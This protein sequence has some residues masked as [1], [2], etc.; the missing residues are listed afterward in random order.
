M[1]NLGQ[2]VRGVGTRVGDTSSA[3]AV[4]I[5]RYVNFRYK[6]IWERF[7]WGTINPSFG[8]N[9]G[10]ARIVTE[11]SF[12]IITETGSSLITED[13][14]TIGCRDFLMPSDFF[15]PLYVYDVTNG[16]DLKELSLQDAERIYASSLKDHGA[17]NVYSLFEKVGTAGVIECWLRLYKNPD[18]SITLMVPYQVGPQDMIADTDTPILDCDYEVEIGATA[19]AWRTKRQFAK[20]ADFEN[21]FEEHI[22]HMIWRRENFSNKVVQFMPQT[23]DKNNLY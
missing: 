13:G 16:I 22:K 8:F 23:F 4:E 1:N 2:I 20:A 3:F 14:T 15:K 17:P 10:S 6:E 7:N 11:D 19:E 21:Q 5:R 9:T 18:S 12:G